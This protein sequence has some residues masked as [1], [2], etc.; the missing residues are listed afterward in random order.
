MRETKEEVGVT[1]DPDALEKIA[2]VTFY[3]S[4]EPS[5]ARVYYKE[6]AKGFLDIDFLPF[7]Q[8][9]AT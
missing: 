5:S 6:K 8:E 2:V 1:L 3:A 9:P 7:T 4:G